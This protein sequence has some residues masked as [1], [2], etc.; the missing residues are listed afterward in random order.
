M[1]VSSASLIG[2]LGQAR[3]PSLFRVMS[4]IRVTPLFAVI[5]G[6]VRLDRCTHVSDGQCKSNVEF[7]P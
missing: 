5:G 1:Q 7:R 6:L 2:R 4:L 3:F